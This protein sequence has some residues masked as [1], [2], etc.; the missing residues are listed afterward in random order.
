MS[1]QTHGR[2]CRR[3]RGVRVSDGAELSS[4]ALY[5]LT[6]LCVPDLHIHIHTHKHTLTLI[7]TR[8]HKPRMLWHAVNGRVSVE[9][10]WV[11]LGVLEAG[12]PLNGMVMHTPCAVAES[13]LLLA[14]GFELPYC[15]APLLCCCFSAS[16]SASPSQSARRVFH[17]CCSDDVGQPAH[18]ALPSRACSLG[19]AHALLPR[20]SPLA[21]CGLV[22]A[23]FPPPPP[24]S[25]AR[26]FWN[27]RPCEGGEQTPAIVVSPLLS[28]E[29]RVNN[30]TRRETC[31]W[32]PLFARLPCRV[33]AP[34]AVALR[35]TSSSDTC[36]CASSLCSSVLGGGREGGREEGRA[37]HSLG[38][39]VC[40]AVFC[41]VCASLVCL[42][43]TLFGSPLLGTRSLLLTMTSLK[44]ML[45]VGAACVAVGGLFVNTSLASVQPAPPRWR[46]RTPS[47]R[48]SSHSRVPA[49]SY[50]AES[51][52]RIAMDE[53]RDGRR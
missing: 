29:R 46:C 7:L 24:L 30:A 18:G 2:T 34:P 10:H 16:L 45:S 33:G 25:P 38:V 36:C 20:R 13:L 41:V 31:R 50:G 19:H 39:Y 11:G 4:V 21:Y 6:L 12:S 27:T 48:N 17:G 35:E 53:K 1:A 37:S 28:F 3:R 14:C 26:P 44:S 47:L 5:E 52:R 49:A 9:G 22:F 51:Y 8:L 32:S 40:C 23:G 15:V 42:L 43:Y